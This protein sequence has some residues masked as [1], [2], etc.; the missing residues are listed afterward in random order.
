M[1][2]ES[3][4]DALFFLDIHTLKK[5]RR[6]GA[7]ARRVRCATESLLALMCCPPDSDAPVGTENG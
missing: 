5:E 1:T 4:L 3:S 6:P 2:Y 7:E